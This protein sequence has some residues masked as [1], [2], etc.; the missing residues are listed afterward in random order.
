MNKCLIISACIMILFMPVFVGCRSTADYMAMNGDAFVVNLDTVELKHD[1][2]LSNIF[3]SVWAI[4][5]DN[6]EVVIGKINRVDVYRDRIIVLD[7]EYAK[8]V[9]AFDRAG[10]LLCKIGNVGLGP[11]EYASCGDFAIDHEQGSIFIYDKL[12]HRIFVYDVNTGKYQRTLRI[13]RSVGFDRIW[14]NGGRLYAVSSYFSSEKNDSPFYI[15]KQLDEKTGKLIGEWL[16]VETFNKGW[17]GEFMTTNLFYRLGGEEDLFTYGIADTILC[18]KEEEI[19]PYM[20]F[21]GDKVIKP[22]EL[23]EEEKKILLNGKEWIEMHSNMHRRL[24]K[25]QQKITCIFD[26]YK[27]RDNLYFRYMTWSRF[28]AQYNLKKK[29]ISVYTNTKD[30]LLFLSKPYKYSMTSFLMSDDGGVYYQV[31]TEAL[32]QLKS[33][34]NDGFL[35]DRIRN[36]EVLRQITEDSNPIILYYEFKKE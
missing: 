34:L 25:Q 30:D 6:S 1:F 31:N 20:V 17:K 3:D 18:M 4:P 14:Y 19:V 21:T 36:K 2:K 7:A 8:G 28:F 5:L 32:P 26:L 12:R 33:C 9:F 24:G 27:N 10:R 11:E 15:L 13:D 22:G 29:E 35:S 23:L 16:D